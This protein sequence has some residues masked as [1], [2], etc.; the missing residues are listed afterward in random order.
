[1]RR[2]AFTLIELLVVIA[3]IAVLLA[4]LLPA[5]QRVREA[6]NRTT[7]QNN[8]KQ[9]ALAAQNYHGA[10][11]RFP[12]GATPTPAQASVLVLLLPYLEQDNTYRQFDFSRD[13]YAD[14]VNAPGRAQQVPIFLCPSDPSQGSYKDLAGNISGKS[15]YAANLGPHG[16][17]KEQSGGQIKDRSLNGVFAM[18]SKTRLTD[19]TDGSSNTLLFAEVKRGASPGHDSLDVTVL[20][21]SD[22]NKS[23]YNP[24]INP[25]NLAPAAACNNATGSTLNFTGL[26]YYRGFFTTAFYTHTVPPNSPN[27]DCICYLT[28]DQGHVAARSYHPGGLNVALADGSVRFLSDAI[29]LSTWKSLGTRSGGEPISAGD[30]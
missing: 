18:N 9:I 11:G 5:V 6:G 17:W 24:A 13:V 19:I 1:M 2:P 3:I 21:S 29:S 23:P 22:W 28:F 10:L 8:L 25:N 30:F 27:R 4:L 16:W 20:M 7:C 15:N 26:Q 12:P 14:P